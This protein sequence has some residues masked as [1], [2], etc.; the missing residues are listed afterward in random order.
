MSFP[1][2]GNHKWD[3]IIDFSSYFPKSLKKTLEQIN[4]EVK[5]YVYISTVSVYAFENYDSSFEIK[6][7]F[8]KVNYTDEEL[9]EK[10]LKYYGKKKWACEEVLMKA[11]WLHKTIL[12]PSFIYGKYDPTDRFY[13]WL[14]KIRDNEQLI[15]PDNGEHK[16]SLTFADDLVEI[17]LSILTGKL[18]SDVFNCN[19]NPP[20]KIRDILEIVKDILG[21]NCK[22][23]DVGTSALQ[24]AGIL[25]PLSMGGNLMFDNSRLREETAINFTPFRDSLIRTADHYEVENWRACSIEIDEKI[26]R[27]VLMEK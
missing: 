12:R 16:L 23:V 2:F 6:E 18:K 10:S 5:Q 26:E 20:M 7:D 3:Y 11:A 15:L 9:I 1:V 22:F 13:Y 25:P 27:K 21:S 19:T 24:E 4:R 8:E 17:I 14:K